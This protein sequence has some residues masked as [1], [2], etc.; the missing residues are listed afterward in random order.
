MKTIAFKM[1]VMKAARTFDSPFTFADVADLMGDD[2]AIGADGERKLRRA[3]DALKRTGA[4]ARHEHGLM[5]LGRGDVAPGASMFEKIDAFMRDN[6]GLM[7]PKDFIG[8]VDLDESGRVIMQRALE[9]GRET[10]R[11]D[12]IPMH[13]GRW[14]WCL[15]EAERLALPVPGWRVIPDL[16][17][18]SR[19]HGGWLRQG[20]SQI[21]AR[22]EAIGLAVQGARD[23]IE[24]DLDTLLAQVGDLFVADIRQGRATVLATN[25]AVPL[26]TYWKAEFKSGGHKALRRAW[27]ELEERA[28]IGDPWPGSALTASTWVAIGEVLQADPCD[29]SR[30]GPIWEPDPEWRNQ[31]PA[32]GSN[33]V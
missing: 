26:S 20:I 13:D 11:Y 27:L 8:H 2:F 16:A 21:V 19:R 15:P 22:R 29:L 1:E 14:W 32:E 18:D 23:A 7:R 30:G 6:A 5:R 17:L 4:I 28:G 24:L 9:A 33:P 31:K 25:P 12:Y 10:G 3:I